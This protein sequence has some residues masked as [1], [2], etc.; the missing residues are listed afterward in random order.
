M[1]RPLHSFWLLLNDRS[2]FLGFAIET[3]GFL[4]YAAALALGSLALV[5]CVGAGGIGVLSFVSA[6]ISH[7]RLDA[8]DRAGVV[9]SGLG[10]VALGLSLIGG[11]AG[12]GRGTISGIVLWLGATA[13][14]AVGVLALGRRHGG[15]AIAYAVAGGLCF[16]IGDLSTKIAT[17]GGARIA[18][19]ASLIVGYTAGTVLL[20]RGYQVGGAL[21]VAGLATLLTNALPIAA[22]TVILDEPVPHGAFGALRLVAF[23][24]VTVGGL[25][26]AHERR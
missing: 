13:L 22:G 20:Q 8:R 23:L 16:S 5:Q 14:V 17:E 6:R 7:R 3:V 11:S 15:G 9:L 19:A 1:R 24:S 2:W 4:L 21:T 12:S 25:L 26:L 10:L 18:F